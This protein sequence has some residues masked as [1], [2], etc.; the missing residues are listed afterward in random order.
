LHPTLCHI[1]FNIAR[2]IVVDCAS[3][4]H[5]APAQVIRSTVQVIP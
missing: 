4:R 1:G 5:C 3:H 2:C